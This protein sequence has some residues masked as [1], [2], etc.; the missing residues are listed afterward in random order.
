MGQKQ[1]SSKK[2]NDPSSPSGVSKRKK[3]DKKSKDRPQSTPDFTTQFP[4]FRL[5]SR[6]SD[7]TTTVGGK[8]PDVRL[9]G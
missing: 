5:G 2:D 1:S 7:A 8:N 4:D 3:R 9:V 6:P